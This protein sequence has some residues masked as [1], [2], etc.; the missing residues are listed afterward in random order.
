MKG[1]KAKNAAKI[2]AV[3]SKEKGTR[4]EPVAA[5]YLKQGW[6][7]LGDAHADGGTHRQLGRCIMPRAGVFARVIH[8]GWVRAGDMVT[9]LGEEK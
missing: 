5:G 7:L 4:K 3:C 1:V 8:G 6:G 2:I 9:L